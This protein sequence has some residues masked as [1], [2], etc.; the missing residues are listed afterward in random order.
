MK[1]GRT[2]RYEVTSIGGEEIRA[3]IPH[4]LPPEP[5]LEM[6]S[7]RRKLL[8]QA[9]LALGRLDSITLQSAAQPRVCLQPVSGH[10]ERRHGGV[11]NMKKK[12][13]V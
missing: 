12:L 9:T 11:M 5:P 1:R 7:D 8:E 6:T 10:P 2:G 4:P 3:F 13:E